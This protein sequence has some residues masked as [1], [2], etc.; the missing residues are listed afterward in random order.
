MRLLG[1]VLVA[2]LAEAYVVPP[3]SQ[4]VAARRAASP[5]PRALSTTAT[6]SNKPTRDDVM[7]VRR[8][9][10][11]QCV[12]G[13]A[14]GG[15]G[16]E[17]GGGADIVARYAAG[18]S[19]TATGGRP[20]RLN[21]RTRGSFPLHTRDEVVHAQDAHCLPFPRRHSGVNQVKGQERRS[22][23]FSRSRSSPGTWS[24][25]SSRLLDEY[26]TCEDLVV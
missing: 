7:R 12:W 20:V 14:K 8:V 21:R 1:L 19:H 11:N 26:H 24:T 23:S 2:C 13:G 22:S 18:S 10:L 3:T 15:W 16:A 5:P 6:L 4:H 9:P 25:L 17:G